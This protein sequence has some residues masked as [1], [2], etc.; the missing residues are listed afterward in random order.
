MGNFIETFPS[1]IRADIMS[2]LFN[3]RF[4]KEGSLKFFKVNKNSSLFPKL[5]DLTAKSLGLT[6]TLKS[7]LKTPEG[8]TAFIYSPYT[9]DSNIPAEDSFIVSG[10]NYLEKKP[11]DI[12][13][14]FSREIYYNVIRESEYKTKK[15]VIN[16]IKKT[17]SLLLF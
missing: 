7:V 15:S 2:S 10:S 9:D 8:K 5:K 17:M 16:I 3:S 11:G 4:K 6:G 12:K 14:R 13:K 1:G